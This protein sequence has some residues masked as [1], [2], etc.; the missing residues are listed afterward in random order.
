MQTSVALEL[1]L[2]AAMAKRDS[3]WNVDRTPGGGLH[4]GIKRPGSSE[5]LVGSDF[6][7]KRTIALLRKL[8]GCSAQEAR[9]FLYRHIKDEG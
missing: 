4:I 6:D 1:D 7:P 2:V 8:T 3:A 9:E 5:V